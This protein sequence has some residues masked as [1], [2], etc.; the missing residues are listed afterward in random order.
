MQT[1]IPSVSLKG[2]SRCLRLSHTQALENYLVHLEVQGLWLSAMTPGW[3]A[4]FPGDLVGKGGPQLSTLR[5]YP[6]IRIYS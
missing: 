1:A 6:N 5:S 4:C 3:D 2:P